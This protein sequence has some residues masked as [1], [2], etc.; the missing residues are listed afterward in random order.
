MIA[1]HWERGASLLAAL[2]LQGGFILILIASLP[3]L[4][5]PVNLVR[6]LTLFLPH[7]T[8]ARTRTGPATLQ[9]APAI[10]TTGLRQ[11][12]EQAAPGAVPAA[13]VPIPGLQNFGQAL[14]GCAPE[15]YARLTAEQQAHCPRPGA[16]VAIQELPNLMG[17]PSHAKDEAHWR[18][19]WAREQS[20]ALL[21][22]GGFV[23]VM[24]LLGKIADGSLSDYGDPSRWPHYAVKQLA[25][26]SFYKVEQAYDAWDKAHP[27]PPAAPSVAEGAGR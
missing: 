12:P 8:P 6:E 5:P 4:R 9:A 19:E 24:C 10:I 27:G 18:D 15:Q 21:P 17:G 22:C 13:P 2:L 14:S 20:P 16:G 1:R 26:E 7:Q 23:N 3:V 25:P 11:P